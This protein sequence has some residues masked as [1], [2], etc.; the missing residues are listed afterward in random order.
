MRILYPNGKK[1]A[2]TFSYD[3]NQVYDRRLIEQLNRYGLKGTFHLNAG[4]I[5]TKTPKDE[6]VTW[7]ELQ[8]L[9]QGHEVACHGLNHPFFGQLPKG[10]LQYEILEDKKRLED[11]VKCPVRGM[12]YPFGEYSDSVILT[13][14]AAGIEY[15]RT[16]NDTRDFV[17]PT[18][19]MKWQ[20][21]CHHNEAIKNKT[22]VERFLN[23]PGH[24]NLP[25]FYIWG[26]S[27]EFE[28]ENTWEYM[29]DLCKLLSGHE[30]VWYATNIQIK[31][32]ICAVR[33]LVFSVD[34]SMIYNPSAI[35]VYF[36]QNDVLHIIQPGDTFCR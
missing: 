16:V 27:F 13:A 30:E 2:L 19:F 32:Y 23:P 12:S 21:T 7:E 31:D 3:D 15:S 18:E 9:Y 6:F 20:P 4:K 22:L 36:D 28:R 17:W 1:K 24:L 10:E 35:P 26:H 25:L 8:E 33:K 5:G 14:E 29:E 34:Q 11:A